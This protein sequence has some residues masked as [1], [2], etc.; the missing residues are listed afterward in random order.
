ML[1]CWDSEHTERLQLHYK[2]CNLR[3]GA[4][5]DAGPTLRSVICV[6]MMGT[7]KAFHLLIKELLSEA[8]RGF[9]DI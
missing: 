7:L 4:G 2:G 5:R 3:V 9:V 6:T 8:E 1:C